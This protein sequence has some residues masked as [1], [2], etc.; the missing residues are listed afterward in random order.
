MDLT[1][2]LISDTYPRLIQID[3][4][5][6]TTQDGLGNTTLIPTSSF[7]L[8]ASLLLGSI[9]S[10]SYA[11]TASTLTGIITS[12]S[13][14]VTSSYASSIIYSN[15]SAKPILL[16][17]SL[18]IASEIS[19][20]SNSLSSSLSTRITSNEASILNST[21]TGSYHETKI[22]NLEVTSSNLII[23][24]A[25]F[26][27][28][29]SIL[30]FK[31]L[32]SSSAQ[33]ST[34]ISGAFILA[35]SSI[36]IRITDTETT[37]SNF[38]IA[39]SSFSS[40]LSI[41]NSKTLLSSSTQIASEISGSVTAFSSS[42]ST[43]AA[44]LETK[45]NYTGSFSGSFTGNVGIG[46][47]EPTYKLDVIGNIYGSTAGV[48]IG[49]A[50]RINRIQIESGLFTFYNAGN[51][52]GGVKFGTGIFT[53]NV[54]IGTTD[55]DGTPA[56]GRLT[57]KG[58]TND[59]STNIL[60][61]RDSDEANV[62][63]IDTNGVFSGSVISSSYA[64]TSSYASSV[65]FSNISAKPSLLSSSAQISSEIS[66]SFTSVSSSISSRFISNETDISNLQ[67]T[68]SNLT[69]TSS[70]HEIRID[71]LEVTASN[72]I[73]A[74]ASFSSSIKSLQ[75]DSS[76]FSLRITTNENDIVPLKIISSSYLISSASV[77]SS[78]A[79]LTNASSS[80]L[81][82]AS[83]SDTAY[84]AGWNGVTT[85]APSKNAV[86]DQMALLIVAIEARELL[87]TDVYVDGNSPDITGNTNCWIEQTA[88]SNP[89]IV[90]YNVNVAGVT[91]F[92]KVIAIDAA[93]SVTLD[94]QDL[95]NGTDANPVL[96]IANNGNTYLY[97]HN[98]TYWYQFSP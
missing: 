86:Y 23:A 80:Y 73:I 97:K 91:V 13:F 10:A 67:T 41:L 64:V 31:T 57:L 51:S 1:N 76:S 28:S 55:L 30:N 82:S 75:L 44:T 27:S 48:L 4:A 11:A 17:S 92:V 46:T 40:S 29:I 59:G 45:T 33:I 32:L 81:T 85:I 50:A 38:I 95:L 53:D 37:A 34:E 79:T 47:T 77:S 43:R 42:I 74:S 87:Y 62:F 60:V 15:I 6:N 18:Q 94:F 69:L 24:S 21:S 39:S 8:T 89:S 7:A 90:F 54:G 5:S 49:E 71:N 20:S 78:I 3:T 25:S 36:S 70:D 35:S 2:N 12:A 16:S 98:G 65:E 96:T 72:F 83:I 52:Y 9:Q 88:A 26:S 58:T 93:G 84:V 14:A 63:S 22:D 61:G 19:G 56:I 68:A 66:G